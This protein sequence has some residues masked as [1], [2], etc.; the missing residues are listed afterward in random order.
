[1]SPYHSFRQNGLLTFENTV[2]L[3]VV[4]LRA[5]ISFAW[6]FFVGSWT[7]EAGF[8]VPFGGFALLMGIFGLTTVP[9][10]LIGKRFRIVQHDLIRRKFFLEE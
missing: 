8:A 5:I 2:V 9:V 6:T 4:T 1:M 3:I 10:W 7:T